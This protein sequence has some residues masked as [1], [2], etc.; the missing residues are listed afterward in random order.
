MKLFIA[1]QHAY[2]I[3]GL[4]LILAI[5]D[6]QVVLLGAHIGTSQAYLCLLHLCIGMQWAKED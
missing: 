6:T 3:Y 1:F 4:R 5:G 2:D